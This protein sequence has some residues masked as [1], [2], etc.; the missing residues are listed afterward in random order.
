[1]SVGVVGLGVMGLPIAL[2]LV[3]SGVA[4]T[5]WTRSRSRTDTAVAAG[6]RLALNPIDLARTSSVMFV[7][8]PDMPQLREVLEGPQGLREG[9]YPGQVLVVMST[10]DPAAVRS[11][12]AELAPFGVNVVDAPISGG[13]IAA[14][15]ATLSIMVGGEKSIVDA[16]HPVLGVIGSTV[17][18][19]GELGSGQLAKACNQ[20]VVAA[21]LAALGEALV[22]ARRAGLDAARLLEALSGGLASSRA[23]ETKRE[24][25][26]SGTFTPGARADLQLKDLGIALGAG[27]ALQAAMPL[28]ALLEQL[29][30]ALCEEGYGGED[31]SGVVRVI[32][33][34]SS[35]E[36]G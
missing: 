12:G 27:E 17:T 35:S 28:T 9:L 2:N 19:M 24:K 8:L 26:L 18:Y 30:S 13:D 21:N 31:H 15:D 36:P 4:T 11:L 34:L 20:I 6:A 33:R 5:V 32:E 22:L 23:L 10:V 7:V 29:Y 16:L 1:M 14:R 25:L 3:R